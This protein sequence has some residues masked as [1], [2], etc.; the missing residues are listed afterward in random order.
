MALKNILFVVSDVEKSVAFYKE[1]F[2]LQVIRDFGSN[3]ILSEGL[4]LQERKTFEELIGREVSQG[5]NDAVLYFVESDLDAFAEKLKNSSLPIQYVHE[6]KEY[7]WGQRAIR[8][9]DPDQHVIELG[10]IK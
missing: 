10:E 7:A 5:G 8:I 3:V 1:F 2:G 6:L 4:V 9:Y